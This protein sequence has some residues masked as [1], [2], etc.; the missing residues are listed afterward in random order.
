MAKIRKRTPNMRE[1]TLYK[2]IGI[3]PGATLEAI[4]HEWRLWAVAL[5]P[6]THPSQS[7]EDAERWKQIN[8]AY[9]TLKDAER[10]TVYDATLRIMGRLNCDICQ[11]TGLRVRYKKLVRTLQTCEV[12]KG[13]GECFDL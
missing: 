5:H 11:G 4:H 8:L 2:L 1:P 13:D 12:C 9:A 7:T 10:R 3:P 6:D